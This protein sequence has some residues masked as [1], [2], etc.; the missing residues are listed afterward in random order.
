MRYF[1]DSLLLKLEKLMNK[2]IGLFILIIL[3]TVHFLPAQNEDNQWLTGYTFRYPGEPDPE[4]F[5]GCIIFDFGYDP[6]RIY[7]EADQYMNFQEE[8][9]SMCDKNG[10]LL[11][12][13]NGMFINNGQF[14]TMENGDTI[15][16]GDFWDRFTRKRSNG[17]FYDGFRIWQGA[18]SLPYPGHSGE[19]I[20]LYEDYDIHN[21]L[22]NHVYYAIIDINKNNGLGK[23]IKK[24]IDLIE[25]KD[26]LD[27]IAD[28]GKLTACKHANGRDWWVIVPNTFKN[29]IY[30]YLLTPSGINFI[31]KKEFEFYR[32]SKSQLGQASFSPD[33]SH[34]ALWGIHVL[35]GEGIIRLY[36]FDRCTGELNHERADTL[37]GGYA[38]GVSFSPNGKYIYFS[39]DWNIFQFDL[40]SENFFSSR[41]IVAVWD[42]WKDEYNTS[43]PLSFMALGQDGKIY[44]IPNGGNNHY[45]NKINYPDLK[46]IDCEVQQH[47]LKMPT[48]VGASATIP[49]YPNFRLGPIDDSVCDT[50]GI[51]NIPVSKFAYEQDS[52]DYLSVQF[53]DLSYF[54]PE[55]YY[56]DFGDGKTSTEINPSHIFAEKGIYEVCLTVSNDKSTDK[57]CRTL[58]IA[59]TDAIDVSAKNL[60]ID[61]FP[62]PVDDILLLTISDYLPENAF[63]VIYSVQGEKAINKKVK[64]GW[65][66]IDVRKLQSG[67][68]IY[69]VLDQDKLLKRGK[70]VID[71]HR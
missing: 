69:N 60:S 21:K 19:Y 4:H 38:S 63:M 57:S 28:W 16:Y 13:S 3:L 40:E 70:V 52:L 41:Q 14:E 25:Q 67:I 48:F 54:E 26:E 33:G 2:R 58:N 17:D 20:M 55:Q 42:R 44:V 66:S 51:D 47:V 15:A 65:N 37:A 9:T 30:I 12:Y 7:R 23:V 39:N 11:F 31:R 49:N 1:L 62:N 43:F 61:I 53:T 64:Y 22:I 68:F 24:D 71:H 50:L 46:G 27:R 29:E 36:D 35:N 59:M 32:I 45:I 10:N 5:F 34:Y 18:L 6:V 8:M 56:W